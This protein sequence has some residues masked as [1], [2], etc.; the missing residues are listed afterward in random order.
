M[1]ISEKKLSVWKE[2]IPRMNEEDL[3]FILEFSECFEPQILKLVK[4]RLE[5][6]KSP[7]GYSNDYYDHCD[8][9]EEE[10]ESSIPEHEAMRDMVMKCLNELGCS[11]ELDEEGDIDF[12]FQGE[13]FNISLG[14]NHHYIEILDYCWKKV[15]LDDTEEVE[16]LKH[17]VNYANSNCSITTAYL[18]DDDFIKVY[19]KTSILYRPMISNI[20][21]YLDIRL[22]N[23]FLAHDLVNSEMTLMA[24]RDRKKQEELE[25][26][27]VDKLSI[28]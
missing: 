23:F 11:C 1:A 6:M 2:S 25:S 27:N 13:F 17:A 5:E 26:L 20:K 7:Q 12:Y 19:C 28:S 21:E 14:E 15:S 3:E 9:K 22:N 24:E 10:N 16:R 8:D 18:T 4:S